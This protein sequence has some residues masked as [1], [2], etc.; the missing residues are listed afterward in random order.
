M[1]RGQKTDFFSSL[2]AQASR[3]LQQLEGQIHKLEAE[4]D[5]LKAHGEPRV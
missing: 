3:V 1:P 2:R 5:D 4:L